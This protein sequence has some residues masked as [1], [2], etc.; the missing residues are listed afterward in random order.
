MHSKPRFGAYRR[1]REVLLDAAASV[2]AFI[3][4]GADDRRALRHLGLRN[5]VFTR[6][7]RPYPALAEAIAKRYRSVAVLT[8]FDLEGELANQKLTRLLQ[9]K[10]LRICGTCRETLKT[11]LAEERITTI[12]GIYQ[13]LI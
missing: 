1:I 8:D 13:L 3:V 4:D 12:E 7:Q 11:L 10:G 6:S 9:A 2:D 5:P